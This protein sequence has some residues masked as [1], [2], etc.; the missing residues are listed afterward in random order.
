[1]TFSAICAQEPM[2]NLCLELATVGDL[3]LCERPQSYTLRPGESKHVKANIKVSSTETGI[4]F[5]SI[6][7]DGNGNNT[8]G[9]EEQNADRNPISILAIAKTTLFLFRFVFPSFPFPFSFPA[10]AKR[11]ASF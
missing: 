4:V 5:G 2:T 1:M 10:L 3:K 8:N 6:V 7:Y 9:A 11:S